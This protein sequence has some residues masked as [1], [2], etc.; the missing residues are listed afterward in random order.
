MTDDPY[1]DLIEKHWDNIIMMYESF[2]DKNPIIEYEVHSKRIYSYPAAEY[3]GTLSDRTKDQ[4]KKQ[5]ENAMK[6]NQFMLFIKDVKS[7][8]LRSYIFECIKV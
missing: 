4:T 2:K 1:L 6:N 7:E 3:I 8:R 5:H